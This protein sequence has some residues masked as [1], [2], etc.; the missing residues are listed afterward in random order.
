MHEGFDC[1][2]VHLELKNLVED[3]GPIGLTLTP[4][5]PFASKSIA[6]PSDLYEEAKIAW[7]VLKVQH[8]LN[9]NAWSLIAS[10]LFPNIHCSE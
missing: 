3:Y 7:E 4:S 9:K 2:E 10:C 5:G 6:M 1:D 8:I